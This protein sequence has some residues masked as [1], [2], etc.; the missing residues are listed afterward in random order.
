MLLLAIRQ[1]NWQ[2]AIAIAREM[3]QRGNDDPFLAALPATLG[4]CATDDHR[5]RTLVSWWAELRWREKQ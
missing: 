1:N 5:A 3:M 4:Q 2:Q